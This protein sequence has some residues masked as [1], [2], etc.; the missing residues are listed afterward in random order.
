MLTWTY[1]Q[2]TGRLLDPAGNLVAIGYAGGNCGK[3]PEGKNNSDIQDVSCVGP[4]PVGRYTFGQPIDHKHLGHYAIPLYPPR[5]R[6]RDARPR[7]VLYARRQSRGTGQRQRRLHHHAA[8][9]A[10]AV[11]GKRQPRQRADLPEILLLTGLS[12]PSRQGCD[13]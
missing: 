10:R 1:E 2:R 4:L 11:L 12:V 9:S 3:N 6:Q 8:R 5:R 13:D 7:R